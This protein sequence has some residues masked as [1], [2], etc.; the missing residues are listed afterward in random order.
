MHAPAAYLPVPAAH[1]GKLVV[2]LQVAVMLDVEVVRVKLVLVVV[3]KANRKRLPTPSGR[4]KPACTSRGIRVVS[5]EE[6]WGCT[7][8]AGSSDLNDK[9]I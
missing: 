4:E 7:S 8:T 6:G 5:T 1:V 2:E 9:M 3:P